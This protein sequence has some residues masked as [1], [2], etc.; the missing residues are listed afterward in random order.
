MTNYV[1]TEGSRDV[2]ILSAVA[3]QFLP[4]RR[5]VFVD[6]QGKSNAVSLA[7]SLLSARKQP[8]AFVVDADTV[9][10]DLIHE[11]RQTLESLLGLVAVRSLWTAALFE[12][13]LER[14]LFRDLGFAER[15]F[16]GLLS[17]RQRVLAEY[18]P[19]RL[20]QELSRE[21]WHTEDKEHAELLRRLSQ[22]DLTPLTEEPAIRDMVKFLEKAGD[23]SAD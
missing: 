3:R 4:G 18:D 17:E 7:R 16:G 19:R 14:C 9:D 21:R 11:Q 22:H 6:G 13:T 5:I 20:L 10:R 1:V 15:L 8:V 2:E 12:P 23:L